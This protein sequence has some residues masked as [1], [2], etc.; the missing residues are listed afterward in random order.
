MMSQIEKKS[1]GL[2]KN[3]RPGVGFLGV[4]WIGL[5]RMEALAKSGLI[6]IK[7]IAE[8]EVEAAERAVAIAPGARIYTGLDEMLDMDL[9]GIVIATPSAL[10]A[11]QSGQALESGRAVFCQKP[12]GRTWEETASVVESARR[13]DRLLGVDL[14]YRHLKAMKKIKNMIAD[15]IAGEI[16]SVNL[17][18]HNA[19]GPDKA[20][21]YDPLL[22]G[23]GCVIDLGT[24]LV[25][26]ALW[27]LG[28][29]RV[30]SVGSR[31]YARGN[32]L[33]P[34]VSEVEDYAVATIGLDNGAT[35]NLACSWRINAG[36]DAVIE[37]SF[38]GTEGGLSLKNV[39]GSFYDFKAELYKWTASETL[40]L[41]PDDWGGRS[42]LQWAEKLAV[43]KSYDPDIEHIVEV[44]RVIDMIYGR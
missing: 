3:T 5:N 37:A 41:P 33:K 22:S 28:Y 38:Y 17:V 25:D 29:P 15:G 10:H 12:L 21:F 44:A 19:Y 11:R 42:A 27:A 43:S 2:I 23:G 26:L 16:F 36:C 14:S 1:E 31:L 8:P 40:E 7:S 24:H 35:V 39:N 4:G 32:L 9:D 6:D 18:F 34:P 30:E 20:W 13:A